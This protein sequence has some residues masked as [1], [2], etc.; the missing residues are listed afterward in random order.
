MNKG[1]DKVCDFTFLYAVFKAKGKS[2][3]TNKTVLSK[4]SKTEYFGVQSLV[5]LNLL[6]YLLSIPYILICG[7]QGRILNIA[8]LF[9]NFFCKIVIYRQMK[10]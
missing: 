3:D 2:Q 9:D 4:K 7:R 8:I 5:I 10:K 6:Y 1:M